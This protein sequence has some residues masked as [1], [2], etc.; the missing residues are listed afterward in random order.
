GAENRLS[1]P[2][3]LLLTSS[4]STG[5]PKAMVIDTDSLWSSG[6][7]FLN[8]HGFVTREDRFWNL[9]PM[10]YLG[11]LFNLGLIPLAAGSTIIVS[12]PF[13]G[14]TFLSFWQMVEAHD[15]SVLWLVPTMVRGLLAIA[16]RTGAHEV[17]KAHRRVRASFLGTA[18]ID[19]PTKERF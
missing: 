18:P 2:G 4:G 11:G 9:L 12:E 15:I 5:E 7:A 6:L 10:S 19:L 1:R 16:E 3:R 17:V 13:S 8:Y 14:K